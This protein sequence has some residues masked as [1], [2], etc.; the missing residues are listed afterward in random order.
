MNQIQC[1]R[2]VEDLLQAFPVTSFRCSQVIA[3]LGS[4]GG[5]APTYMQVFTSLQLLSQ[6]G[7][8]E[9]RGT[10]GWYRWK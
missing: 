5:E 10:T 3:A 1:D 9:K 2:L 6:R 7:L 8:L 4:E